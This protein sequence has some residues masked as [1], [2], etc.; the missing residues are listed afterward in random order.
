MTGALAGTG[1][2]ARLALRRD[3]VL[4]PIWVYVFVLSAAGSGRA[5]LELYPDARARA[6]AARAANATTALVAMYGRVYDPGSPGG[7]A[8]LKLTVL[9]CV[10]LAALAIMLVTRHT[11]AE[12]EQGR[13]ELVG[14]GVVGRYAPLAAA[15]MVAM[16]ASV[17]IGALSGVGLA[18]VGLPSAG[19]LAFAVAWSGSGVVFAALA[20]LCA[21]LTQTARSANGLALGLLAVTYLLRALGD[22][23]SSAVSYLSPIGWCQQ[24]RPYGGDRLWLAMLPLGLAVLLVGGAVALVEHR[25]LG[26]GVLPARPGRSTAAGWLGSPQALAWRLQRGALAGWVAAFAA[27]GTV[28]GGLSGNLGGLASSAQTRDLIARMGGV[29]G[30]RDA[31]LSTE[32]GFMALASAVFGIAAAAR[33]RGE[34]SAGRGELVLA[35]AGSRTRWAGGHIAVAVLGSSA[36]M[37]IGSLG[38]VLGGAGSLSTMLTAGLARLPAVWV[39]TALAVL[40]FGVAPRLFVLAW[41][42]LVVS[43]LLGELGDAL[44]VPHALQQVSPFAH[45]PDLPGGT[46]SWPSLV[47]LVVLA[48]VLLGCGVAA[49]GRRDLATG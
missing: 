28:L 26:S 43:L 18:L 3:R 33:L 41:A 17:L 12:E 25:D 11:R 1:Q 6:A 30:L 19:S 40:L 10:L 13:L 4:I 47:V 7:I 16:G 44:K 14:A 36:L 21:Q 39:L 29:S 46:T 35:A 37:L 24:I 9:G 42:A 23:E 27:L 8:M 15:L 2:L 22:T 5:G 48:V 45:T 20:G 31:F 38:T 32:L 49:L 34:E